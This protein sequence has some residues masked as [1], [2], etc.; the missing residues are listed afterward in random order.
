M[1]LALTTSKIL[2]ATPH[3]SVQNVRNA[4]VVENNAT[5]ARPSYAD[6]TRDSPPKP[7]LSAS[8]KVCESEFHDT[9]KC[10]NLVSLSYD[11]KSAQIRQRQL[12][13]G[14]LLPG[15]LQRHYPEPPMC[16]KC[17]KHGHNELFC[18][19]RPRPATSAPPVAAAD[20]PTPLFDLNLSLASE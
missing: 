20:V 7:Q 5:N 17:G 11:E 2:S 15:H 16:G 8:C 3:A 13:Y 14:F 12:C 4:G 19:W 1:A 10:P 6:A 18:G 9:I